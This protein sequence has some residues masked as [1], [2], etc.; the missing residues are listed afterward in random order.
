GVPLVRPRAAIPARGPRRRLGR[1]EPGRAPRRYDD[2]A[3]RAGRPRPP[4]AG[5]LGAGVLARPRTAARAA[6]RAGRDRD[7]ALYRVELLAAAPAARG[8]GGAAG[9]AALGRRSFH[10]GPLTAT[11]RRRA[12]GLVHHR[13]AARGHAGLPYRR[14]RHRTTA[15]TDA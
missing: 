11:A 4:G 7:R 3:G 6:A 12:A 13:V 14:R 2:V 1:N 9:S 5:L 8:V 10:G 15:P